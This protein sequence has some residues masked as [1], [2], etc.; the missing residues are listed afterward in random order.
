MQEYKVVE[1]SNITP[2]VALLTL[3]SPNTNFSFSAGQYAALHFKSHGRPSPVRCFSIVSPS[4]EQ[5][6]LQFAFRITGNYSYRLSQ[7][8]PGDSVYVQGPFGD[9]TVNPQYD[10][11][12]VFMAGGIGITPFLSML[13]SLTK[14]RLN[15]PVTLLYSCRD[16]N[17]VPFADQLMRLQRQNPNLKVVFIL[18]KA[19]VSARFVGG[20]VVTGKIDDELIAKV[21]GQVAADTTYFLCGPPKFMDSLSIALAHQGVHE[22]RIVMEAF[23]QRAGTAT[24]LA[25]KSQRRIYSATLASIVLGVGILAGSGLV[26]SAQAHAASLFKEVTAEGSEDGANS[27]STAS[28][29]DTSE[30]TASPAAASN[31][32]S[33]G[34]SNT[35]NTAPATTQYYQQPMSSVS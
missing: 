32:A 30:A 13:Q 31:Q 9:F 14:M 34:T 18:G 20:S 2:T 10:R 1:L 19:P 15:I 21:Y 12:L 11:S 33:P 35:S 28:S 17:D 6:R 29:S 4:Q 7:L 24:K 22:D 3:E 16:E 5:N 8:R 25:D 23:G 27:T 26:K